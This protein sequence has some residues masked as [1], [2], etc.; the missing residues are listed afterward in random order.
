M[1]DSRT[2][3]Y[4]ATETGMLRNEQVLDSPAIESS[5]EEEVLV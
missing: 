5:V 4:H 1:N 2:L 3:K